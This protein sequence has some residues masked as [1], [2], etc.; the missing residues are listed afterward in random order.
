MN[1]DISDLVVKVWCKHELY[2]MLYFER[3]RDFYF[4][5]RNYTKVL[6]SIMIREI[7]KLKYKKVKMINA[8]QTKILELKIYFFPKQKI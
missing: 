1:I 5:S 2:S 6:R 4:I 7:F 8:L 3:E